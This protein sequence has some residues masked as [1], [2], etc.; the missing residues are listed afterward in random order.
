MGDGDGSE[1]RRAPR[2]L[3]D[4]EAELHVES[5]AVPGTVSDL[6]LTGGLFIPATAVGARAGMQG[7]LHIHVGVRLQPQVRIARVADIQTS[8]VPAVRGVGIE[9][10][11]LSHAERDA[12]EHLLAGAWPVRT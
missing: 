4:V 9:F 6:S 7:R 2:V 3:T 8:S 5:S 10:L 12:I 11:H 1:R